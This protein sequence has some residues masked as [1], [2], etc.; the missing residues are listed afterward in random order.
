MVIANGSYLYIGFDNT[1]GIQIWRTDNTNPGT[2]TSDW[3]QIGTDGLGDT[4]NNQQIFSATSVQEGIDY[5]LYVSTGKSDAP[6]SVYRQ[7]NN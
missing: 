3:V 2:G 6:V 1:N 7:K 4:T 5:Y